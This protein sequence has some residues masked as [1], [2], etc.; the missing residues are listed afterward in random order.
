MTEQ[1]KPCGCNDPYFE[2]DERIGCRLGRAQPA[3]AGFDDALRQQ[4]PIHIMDALRN[5]EDHYPGN[6]NTAKRAIALLMCLCH[7]AADEIQ[8]LH[9]EVLRHAQPAQAGQV[10]TDDEILDLAETHGLDAFVYE[11]FARAIE[12]AVLAKRVPMTEAQINAALSGNPRVD[13]EESFALGVR[14][15]EQFHGIVG[16]KGGAT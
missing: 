4:E 7:D 12:Q 9:D 1:L 11:H 5:P 10:L 3:Q 2:C 13:N 14:A 8:R 6:F 16:E 15:A